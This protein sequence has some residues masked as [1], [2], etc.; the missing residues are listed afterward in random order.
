MSANRYQ[1]EQAFPPYAYLPGIN[2]HPSHAGGYREGLGEPSVQANSYRFAL[3]LFNH[4]YFWESHV[5]FEA[6]WN[7]QARA[8][9]SGDFFKALIKLSAAGVKL[10]SGRTETSILHL[11]RAHELL[12]TVAK[13]EG[14]SFL[15]VSLNKLLTQL[16]EA[17]VA[18]RQLF[19]ITV[20][21]T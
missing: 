12:S 9:S 13:K 21:D 1:P 20:S 5:Y 8:G 16:Q 2:V 3:D 14:D 6:L 18:P 10:K 11:K 15:G 4:E 19:Q 7:A 17:I